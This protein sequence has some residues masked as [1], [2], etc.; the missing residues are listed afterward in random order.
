MKKYILVLV[1]LLMV[2]LVGCGEEKQSTENS[3]DSLASETEAVFTHEEVEKTAVLIGVDTDKSEMIFRDIVTGEDKPLGYHGGIS[4]INKHQSEMLFDDLVLGGVYDVTY[5]GDTSR[6]VKIVENSAALT[7]KE[8]EK[9]SADKN[10]NTAMYKGTSCK[11]S[12]H[13]AAFDKDTLIDVS[14]IN[15]EDQLTI[16]Y[17]GDKLV[18]VAIDL[19]HGYVRLVNQDTYIGG[20]V[21][22][23]YDVVVPVTAN[24]L[25]PV[26][27]GIYTLRINRAGYRENKKVNVIRDR[28]CTV[29]VGD[30]AIPSG[31]VNFIVTPEEAVPS[32]Y[33][34]DQ[35]YEGLAFT[36]IY[37]TSYSYV[38]KA[39]GYKDYKGSINIK[40]PFREYTVKLTPDKGDSDKD[41]TSETTTSTRTDKS[42]SGSSTSTNGSTTSTGNTTGADGSTTT[43]SDNTTGADGS[44]TTGSDNTTGTDG[45]TTTGSD[46]GSSKTTMD[47]ATSEVSGENTKDTSAGSN[48]VNETTEQIT[49][50]KI[51]VK[52]PAEIGVYFDGD[53]VGN[54]PV[55]FPK[56]VGT[57][58]ITLYKKGYLI[59]SYTIQATDDGK[60]MECKYSP[61]ISLTDAINKSYGK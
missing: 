59:K 31:V 10:T 42:T 52:E 22:I 43:G 40:E 57:H 4:I 45:S 49:K 17:Y 14:E 25:V 24:M 46:N 7:L 1:T 6:I 35:Y 21:E 27:E 58:T 44:T 38:I 33:V 54:S 30:L 9:F 19:G 28:E 37:N 26:R 39:E 60:D 53:Y 51:T 8:I 32:L 13:I 47:D 36:A 41:K 2:F 34:N 15:L 48:S 56:V 3:E 16:T 61:L 18:S 12:E 50:N 20:M 5:Y 29:D 55:S 11:I 23:G